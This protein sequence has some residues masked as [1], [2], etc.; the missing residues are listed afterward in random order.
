MAAPLVSME[1]DDE[2]QLDAVCPI[3]VKDRPRF[4]WGLRICLTHSEMEKLGLDLSEAAVGGI[5]TGRFEAC[6]TSVSMSQNEDR[7]DFRMELQIEAL[8][9]PDDDDAEGNEI[10]EARLASPRQARS[11]KSEL[12]KSYTG[13]QRRDLG[14]RPGRVIG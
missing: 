14:V 11:T 8:S 6:I 5:V 12:L 3:P 2:D 13:Q 4:P 9:I 1:M 10:E 7:N